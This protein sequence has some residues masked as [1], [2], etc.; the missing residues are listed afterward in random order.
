M[1]QH[2]STIV[3]PAA[4]REW[5]Y[6]HKIVSGKAQHGVQGDL[7]TILGVDL[8]DMKQMCLTTYNK[9]YEKSNLKISSKD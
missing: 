5:T 3:L 8:V 2:V 1:L 9:S 6:N 4:T 7:A